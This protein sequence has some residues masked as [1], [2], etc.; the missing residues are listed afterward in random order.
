MTKFGSDFDG[1]TDITPEWSTLETEQA[2][3]K[4]YLQAIARRI[5]DGPGSFYSSTWGL[6]ISRFIG[7]NTPAAVIA[8]LV[9]AEAEKDERTL[10][11]E[12]IGTASGDTISGALN[13][14]TYTGPFRLTFLVS[15]ASAEVLSDA[16]GALT[17]ED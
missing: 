6:G 16:F 7:G 1:I 11:A 10:S 8:S 12:F 15:R 14:Q 5:I 17:L 2:Q 9:Q 13:L 3:A 4:A